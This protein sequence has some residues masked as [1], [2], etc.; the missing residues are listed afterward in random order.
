M[1]HYNYIVITW[2]NAFF[3][4][5]LFFFLSF[6]SRVYFMRSDPVFFKCLYGDT[7]LTNRGFVKNFQ[8]WLGIYQGLLTPA[9]RE[10]RHE[11]PNVD[12]QCML[13]RYREYGLLQTPWR[14]GVLKTIPTKQW[15]IF[16]FRKW[17]L[18]L[19]I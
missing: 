11:D 9:L 5:M 18:L 3:Y 12:A 7:V 8:M 2:I 4:H 1:E 13:I 16:S 19:I 10:S 14:F 17:V 15:R 6:Y